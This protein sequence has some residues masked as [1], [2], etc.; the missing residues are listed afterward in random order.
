MLRCGPCSPAEHPADD[1]GVVR[2]LPPTSSSGIAGA[3][4]SAT[5]STVNVRT[6]SSSRASTVEMPVVVS[7][8]RPL[9]CTTQ[10]A[11]E[12]W[13]RSEASIRSA[14]A[15]LAT[16]ISWRRTRPGLAIGPSR[17]NTVGMPISRAARRGEAER[18]VVAR[19]E[20][21]ADPGL[22]DAPP[23]PDRVELDGDAERLEHVGRAALR[24]RARAP[25]LHTGTPAPA[26]T[27][28]AMVD[29]LIE[30]LRSPPVPT[31]SMALVPL[32]LARAAR[33]RRRRARRRAARTPPRGSHPW[34]AARRR[35]RSTGPRVA[36]PARIVRIAARAWAAEVAV[37]DQLG[38]QRRPT[39]VVFQRRVSRRWHRRDSERRHGRRRRQSTPPAGRRRIRPCVAAGGSCRRRSRSVAPPQTPC[40]SR[41]CERVLQAGDAH[42]ALGAHRL[43]SSASSSSSG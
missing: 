12:P 26:T 6:S 29:T 39:A 21:E 16:P 9:P 35:S 40:F 31:M 23:D 1:V 22:V 36:L 27:M 3:R 7:S 24:R 41:T 10:A 34:S 13:R 38:Q 32:V 25:C 5:G 8:S 15:G 19:R 28:A 17:L 18:R 14:T 43:A 30:W 11:C 20:A 33:S 37:L 42:G 4:P 2:R